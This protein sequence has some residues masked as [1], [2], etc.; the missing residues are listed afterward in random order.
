[1]KPIYNSTSKQTTQFL[2]TSRVNILATSLGFL[3]VSF[4]IIYYHGY[5]HIRCNCTKV[6]FSHKSWLRPCTLLLFAQND[7]TV[8]REFFEL[9]KHLFIIFLFLLLS[10]AELLPLLISPLSL[11]TYL[12]DSL[13]TYISFI[14]SFSF[15]HMI[16]SLSPWILIHL[17]LT[18]FLFFFDLCVLLCVCRCM[19]MALICISCLIFYFFSKSNL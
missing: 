1:M 14:A 10:L 2:K 15:Y 3:F 7:D 12:F 4:P 16:S 19:S 8:S 9:V 13:L 18:V 11:S 6:A 5:R 17:C